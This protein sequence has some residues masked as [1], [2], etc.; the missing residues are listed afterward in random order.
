MPA[1]EPQHFCDDP[2]TALCGRDLGLHNFKL[3]YS[4]ATNSFAAVTCR[5]CRSEIKRARL[6][7]GG[8]AA[9]QTW[10]EAAVDVG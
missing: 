1:R 9:P 8:F 7:P 6:D 4:N 3:F 5:G 2:H 10:E